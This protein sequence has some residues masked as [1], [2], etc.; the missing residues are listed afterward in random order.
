MEIS[1]AELKSLLVCEKHDEKHP[2]GHIGKRI[3]ILQRGWVMVGDL[4]IA[5]EECLLKDASV[6]RNW[7]TKKGLG[8][9]ALGGPTTQTVLE[10][11]GE[12]TFH[13]LTTIAEIK[14]DESKW[15]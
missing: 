1:F 6:I 9:I 14:C 4:S 15:K 12:V 2:V 3:V 11:C 10:P 7:G 5:G 13:R 8:E